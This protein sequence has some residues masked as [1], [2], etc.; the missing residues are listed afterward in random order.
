MAGVVED[1]DE[2]DLGPDVP[3]SKDADVRASLRVDFAVIQVR[4]RELGIRVHDKAGNVFGLPLQSLKALQTVNGTKVW[5][6]ALEATEVEQ[7]TK[8]YVLEDHEREL[9]DENSCVES[10]S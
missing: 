9:G 4:C 1:D 5:I 6:V 3:L 10:N 8:V 2:W 7:S